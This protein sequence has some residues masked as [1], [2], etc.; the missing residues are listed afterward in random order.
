MAARS[1]RISGAD[2]RRPC[3]P[4]TRTRAAGRT[5]MILQSNFLNPN[6]A[7]DGAVAWRELRYGRFEI[8]VAAI[9][10]CATVQIHASISGGVDHVCRQFTVQSDAC[11][12]NVACDAAVQAIC[13]LVDNLTQ[14]SG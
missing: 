11:D 7:S 14:R 5:P 13:R 12:A 8:V 1:P 2:A 3:T 10:R 9:E 4:A 6:A